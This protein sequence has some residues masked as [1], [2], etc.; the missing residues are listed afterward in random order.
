MKPI[1]FASLFI[2]YSIAVSSMPEQIIEFTQPDGQKLTGYVRGD[3]Y[4][5]WI[6]LTDGSIVI[7]NPKSRQYEYAIIENNELRSSNIKVNKTKVNRTSSQINSLQENELFKLRK[8]KKE[9]IKF[10]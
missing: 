10:K 1:I 9:Q 5:N 3:E 6:K 7:Y 4:L 8:K 2:S